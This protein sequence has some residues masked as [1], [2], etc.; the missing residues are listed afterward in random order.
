[1][2]YLY[3][4][5]FGQEDERT[6]AA[7]TQA[8]NGNILCVAS[9]GDLPLS[10]LALGAR[11]V[12]AVDFSEPQLHLCRL[13][14]ASIQCLERE[15]AA[16]L[17]GFV[18]ASASRRRRWLN[19]CLPLMPPEAAEFWNAH[20]A[21]VCKKGAIWCGRHEQFL[22]RLRLLL[23]PALGHAFEE[24]A[25]CTDC[26]SQTEIFEKRI[27]RIWLRMV[28]RLAFHPHVFSR[29]GMDP[30]SLAHRQSP[31][32][33]GDQYWATFRG[34]CTRTPAAVNP[35]LQLFLTGRLISL[36]AAPAYLT[37]T[38]FNRVKQTLGFLRLVKNDLLA[39]VRDQMPADM[40]KVCLSNLPDW[41]NAEQFGELISDLARKLAPGSRLVWCYL[42]ANRQLPSSLSRQVLLCEDLGARLHEQD[43]FPFYHIVPARIA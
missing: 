13:K 33:L 41:L 23:R 5:G 38:G 6:Q 7:A 36:D 31:V 9:A 15:E 17:L 10:L 21:A 18:P 25:H 3:N 32:S 24:L 2:A 16:G 40:N 29:R 43:R 19:E 14:S 39:F 8:E 22:S 30:R 11:S 4:F 42:H 20:A 37:P 12:T 1:M 27:N 28:F 34:F 35:W 26:G